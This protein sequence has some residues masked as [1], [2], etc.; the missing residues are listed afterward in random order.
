MVMEL[1]QVSCD[2]GID[3]SEAF[4]D[5]LHVDEAEKSA[6]CGKFQHRNIAY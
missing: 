4:E 2:V 1:P 5:V 3:D 6:F